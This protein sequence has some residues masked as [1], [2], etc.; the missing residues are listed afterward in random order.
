MRAQRENFLINFDMRSSREQLIWVGCL[1]AQ[2][3]GGGC[4]VAVITSVG[5]THV[6]V[7]ACGW[8]CRQMGRETH[9]QSDALH[10][11]VREHY[12]CEPV[13]KLEERIQSGFARMR[14]VA[15]GSSVPTPAPPSSVA[16]VAPS[17]S[18]AAR[19]SS[20]W[21][22]NVWSNFELYPALKCR[23]TRHPQELDASC[24]ACA[25]VLLH[26]TGTNHRS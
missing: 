13:T 17:S 5:P 3:G 12:D 11:R 24:C 25:F 9:M 10:Q 1:S 16:A 2:V 8:T 21:T 14:F 20:E 18:A 23:S 15:V 22:A 7:Q 19:R 6:V 4:V 26:G